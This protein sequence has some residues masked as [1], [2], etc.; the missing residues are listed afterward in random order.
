MTAAS[1]T[2]ALRN[3]VSLNKVLSSL[4]E[5]DCWELLRKER[6]GSQRPQFIQRIFARA[7]KLRSRRELKEM[8]RELEA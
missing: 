2:N 3:W 1:K 6:D 4:E 8:L 5:T 7:S